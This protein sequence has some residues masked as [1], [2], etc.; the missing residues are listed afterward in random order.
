MEWRGKRSRHP[1]TYGLLAGT[2]RSDIADGPL[3]TGPFEAS[4]VGRGDEVMHGLTDR[5]ARAA[6]ETAAPDLMVTIAAEEA[7]RSSPLVF[8]MLAGAVTSFIRVG[9][10]DSEEGIWAA[11]DDAG[12]RAGAW[13][14]DD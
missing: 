8:F 5:R 9:V 10:P 12:R 14:E 6:I 13:A 7:H 1:S 3:P 4:L 11:L 2:L